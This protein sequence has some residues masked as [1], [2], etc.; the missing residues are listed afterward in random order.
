MFFLPTNHISCCSTHCCLSH[1]G[2]TEHLIVKSP[3]CLDRNPLSPQHM[4]GLDC[5]VTIIN[6]RAPKHSL[7]HV[8]A[9]QIGLP[10][11]VF[12]RSSLNSFCQQS[13]YV[14]LYL[15]NK[16]HDLFLVCY[17]S[18][19]SLNDSLSKWWIS[20]WIY[21]KWEKFCCLL[22]CTTTDA[23]HLLSS[24]FPAVQTGPT[25]IGYFSGWISRLSLKVP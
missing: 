9:L 19:K 5:A 21:M 10:F 1:S 6:G 12:Y 23:R 15:V 25:P 11:K 3:D 14:N 16:Y 8:E 4:I 2:T 13:T 7:I 17:Q 20:F 18:Y 22:L 24:H